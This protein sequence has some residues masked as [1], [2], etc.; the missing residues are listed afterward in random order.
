M[1]KYDYVLFD[2]DGTLSASAD[3][4]RKCVELTMEELGRPCPDLSDYSQYI[5]PPLTR[6]FRLLCG[7]S[8]SEVERA[9]PVYRRYY[10]AVG[11]AENRLF[12]GTREAL[13]ALKDGGV[14]LAVCSSKN[15][16]LAG[17]VIRLLDIGGYFDAVCGSCDDGSRKEKKDLIPYALACLRCPDRSRAVMIG[18]TR[19]DAEGARQCGIDFIGVTY[20][21]G[22]KESMAAQGAVGFADSPAEILDYL[23]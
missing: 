23:L 10:D 17:D 11:T 4:I 12:D 6:T 22:T 13:A 8:D 21:Y 18:D 9:L 5:G 14:R 16:R 2:L 15:E 7:L 20:G 3:G 19:F 1:R